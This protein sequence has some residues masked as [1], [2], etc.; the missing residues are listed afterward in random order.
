MENSQ[1]ASILLKLVITGAVIALLYCSVIF[2]IFLI[3]RKVK[4]LFRRHLLR[5]IA[6]NLATFISFIFVIFFWI[7]NVAA[8]SVIAGGLGAVFVLALHGPL[9]KLFGWSIIGIKRLYTVGDRIEIGGL[10]GDVIDIRMLY[11]V[12]LEVGNR[13]GGE[14][15][16]GRVVFVPNDQVFHNSVFNYT[17]GFRYIWNEMTFTITYD[18]DYK[19]AIAILYDILASGELYVE[20]PAK[21]GITKLANKFAIEYEKLTPYVWLR[22]GECGINLTVRYLTDVWEK[23]VTEQF[24]SELVLERFKKEKISLAYPTYS[25]IQEHPKPGKK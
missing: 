6:T 14:Q 5:K 21:D 9:L 2:F 15:S 1:A 22:L 11:T 17:Y 10:K 19:K 13:V 12:L 7:K 18:S 24:I 23:R 25:I 3:N 16:T 8:L 20:K 4:D